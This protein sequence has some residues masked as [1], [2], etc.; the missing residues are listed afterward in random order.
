[1]VG[2]IAIYGYAVDCKLHT[3]SWGGFQFTITMAVDYNLQSWGW[4]QLVYCPVA[5]CWQGPVARWA[6]ATVT[7]ATSTCV[8]GTAVLP[9]GG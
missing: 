6:E 3:Q 2:W 1:M 8:S 7:T 9:C 4:L 5:A